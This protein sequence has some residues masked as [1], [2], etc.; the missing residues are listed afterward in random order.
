MR[1]ICWFYSYR[2]I[3]LKILTSMYI[4]EYLTKLES[5]IKMYKYPT[6][7]L[8]SSVVGEYFSMKWQ[9]H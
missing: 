2:Y 6:Q 7:L 8:P 1:T 9:P 5:E 4:K 3:D